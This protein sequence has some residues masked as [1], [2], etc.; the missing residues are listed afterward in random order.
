[1]NLNF[2]E[3]NSQNQKSSQ[4]SNKKGIHW[5]DVGQNEQSNQ[6]LGTIKKDTRNPG[7]RQI[8]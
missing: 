2:R 1:M 4:H 3:N 5:T 6:M 7:T 8:I